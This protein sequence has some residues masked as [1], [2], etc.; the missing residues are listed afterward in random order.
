[1]TVEY[2]K[3]GAEGDTIVS[4]LENVEVGI[5]EDGDPITSC[6][7]CRPKTAAGPPFR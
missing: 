7:W 5:D 2:M 1:M 4:R 6:V 3:D